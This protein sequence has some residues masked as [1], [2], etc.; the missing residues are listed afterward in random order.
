MHQKKINDSV[1]IFVIPILKNSEAFHRLLNFT[2]LT[3][4][5]ETEEN[6]ML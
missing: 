3:V 1:I 4:Y 5:Y 6:N 2:N